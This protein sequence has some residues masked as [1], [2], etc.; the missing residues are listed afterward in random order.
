LD[1]P[2]LTFN[3]LTGLIIIDK[4]QRKPSLF[5]YLRVHV[6]R[7]PEAKFLLLGSS[8]PDL[9][10]QSAESLAGRIGYIELTPFQSLEVPDADLLWKKGGFPKAYLAKNHNAAEIWL[11]QYI[12]N[13]LERDLHALGFNVSPEEMRK[14]W[15]MSAHYHG[16]ILNYSEL[17]RSLHLS[18]MTIR[19]YLSILENTFMIRLLKPWHENI[20]KRQIKNPKLY[21]RDSGIFHNLLG[22][23]FKDLQFHP[24]VGASFEGFALEECI[25]IHQLDREDCFFWRT[26]DGAELDLFTYKN[27]KRQ[28]FEFKYTENVK[29]TR[30][31]LIA[32]K[33]LKLER[34]TVII[35]GNKRYPIHDNIMVEGLDTLKTK[36]S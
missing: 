8:S 36:I 1:N 3:Q 10:R 18:D 13:F 22:I 34:L 15:I 21:I 14:L 26:H 7:N 29:P 28:G 16:Q 11:K 4:I 23:S 31:M 9:M 27:G 6:D 24:K 20:S 5:P 33:D 25:R 19:K 35:P 30:S 32:L 12:L 17:G 2:Q